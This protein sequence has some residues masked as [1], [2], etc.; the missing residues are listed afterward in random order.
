M[1]HTAIHDPCGIF[2]NPSLN[3]LLYV[4]RVSRIFDVHNET[5]D[6]SSEP[7]LCRIPSL[8]E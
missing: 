3:D 6:I 4:A 2:S 1:F 5:I 7:I 8:P